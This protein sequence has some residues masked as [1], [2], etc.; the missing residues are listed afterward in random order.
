MM[1]LSIFRQIIQQQFVT[2]NM[3]E[4]SIDQHDKLI[5]PLRNRTFLPLHCFHN[6]IRDVRIS[7]LQEI[8]YILNANLTVL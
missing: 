1:C 2:L 4:L 6:K 5:L 7:T 3:N 8:M